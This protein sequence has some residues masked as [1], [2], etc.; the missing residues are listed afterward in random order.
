M[1]L[2]SCILTAGRAGTPC[3]CTTILCCCWTGL[4]PLFVPRST[5]VRPFGACWITCRATGATWWPALWESTSLRGTAGDWFTT[6]PGWGARTILCPGAGTW[7]CGLHTTQEHSS[8][9]V[10]FTSQF[11]MPSW[12]VMGI[13]KTNTST[14][15]WVLG[16][17]LCNLVSDPIKTHYFNMSLPISYIVLH[18]NLTSALSLFLQFSHYG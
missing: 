17:L 8:T 11:P 13:T 3:C 15:S 4:L 2:D 1:W 5:T 16:L 10:S 18:K 6:L 12:P 14:F 7:K 9:T